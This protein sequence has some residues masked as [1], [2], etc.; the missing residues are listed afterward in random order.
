VKASPP[1]SMTTPSIFAQI[2]MDRLLGGNIG[3]FYYLCSSEIWPDKRSSLY[4][5][6]AN[7]RGTT[8]CYFFLLANLAVKLEIQKNLITTNKIKKTV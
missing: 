7:K 2:I 3:V 4:L 8:V 5:E 6:W 1:L